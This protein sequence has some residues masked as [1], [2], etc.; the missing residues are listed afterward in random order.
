MGEVS[1]SVPDAAARAARTGPATDGTPPEASLAG[2]LI[3]L[4]A[5]ALTVADLPELSTSVWA[6]EAAVLL[7]L[8][9]AGIPLLVVRAWGRGAPVRS[10]SEV[11][12]A[13]SALAFIAAAGVAT[14]LA[15]RPTLA[16]VGLYNEGTGLA[17]MVALAGCW[18]LGSWLGAP[19]RR[20][21]GT[22]L[23]A[24]ALV[25]AAVAVLQEFGLLVHL[26]LIGDQGVP[27]G[28]LGNPVDTGAL[29]AASLVLVAPRFV[30]QPRRWWPAAAMIGAGLGLTGERLSGLV[31]L[32]VV[33]WTLWHAYRSPPAERRLGP[34]WGYAVSTLGGAVAG[35]IVAELRGGGGIA[36]HVVASTSGETFGQRFSVWG[37]AVRAIGHHPIFGAG[38]GQFRTA[39]SALFSLSSSR[40]LLGTVFTD[41]HNLVL[42]FATSTGLVGLGL[43]VGWV[44][45][46]AWRRHG[47]FIGF[48]L[49]LGVVQLA[50]PLNIAITPLTFLA[51]GA[52][53]L[54][55][56]A[57]DAP[58]SDDRGLPVWLRRSSAVLALVACVPAVLLVLGDLALN[59]SEADSSVARIGP[60]L[61]AAGTAERFLSPWPDPA[62][63]MANIHNYLYL[64]EGDSPHQAS[65]AV[66]WAAVAAQRDPG[67]EQL[68]SA[69]A[70]AQAQ[71]GHL[72]A[73]EVSDR[74]AVSLDPWSLAPLN[75]LGDIGE[76]EHHPA[77]A[78]MW[79][80][81]SLAVEPDQ[82]SV[83]AELAGRCIPPQ[84]SARGFGHCE[85]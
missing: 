20:A 11:W 60:A 55:P 18:A 59:R 79:L 45:L 61:S 25:N 29:L 56:A 84:P 34:T 68:W 70:I 76:W 72:A 64:A 51:L 75:L 62:T 35:A 38:P 7:V 27:D 3:A 28:L 15:L 53:M 47:P 19:E 80:V 46:G 1:A 54:A 66:R 52:A 78:R 57:D 73:A 22:A 65:A 71:A 48:A 67:N 77:E 42:E 6:P 83:R 17:F 33:G 82:R 12:A 13:R 30:A 10:P 74:R 32:V 63:Q 31:A 50:E 37:A 21:L 14:A 26:G 4:G 24:G 69:L 58:T 16:V 43:L 39:T 2:R 8:G 5:L 44:A 81:R 9:A 36:G 23:I 49:A 40:Q 85:H 41:A